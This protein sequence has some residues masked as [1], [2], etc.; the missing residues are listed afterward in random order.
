MQYSQGMGTQQALVV[1]GDPVSTT[2][3]AE[4]FVA[5]QHRFSFLVCCV[6]IS[7]AV[8]LLREHATEH[9]GRLIYRKQ[10]DLVSL[11]GHLG[12]HHS[13]KMVCVSL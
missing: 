13:R 5:E 10:A 6:G 3:G 9:W 11:F 7:T 8:H 1:V 12:Y 2:D 4:V